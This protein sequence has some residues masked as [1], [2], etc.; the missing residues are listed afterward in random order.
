MRY[1]GV[2]AML[3]GGIVTLWRLRTRIVNALVEGIRV[4]RGRSRG[5]D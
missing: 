4:V 3:T 5:C 2:G 1:L